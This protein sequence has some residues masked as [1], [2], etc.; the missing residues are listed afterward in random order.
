MTTISTNVRASLPKLP[1]I[2]AL[3]V[4]ML[5]CFVF[6]KAQAFYY[7]LNSK[8]PGCPV[9]KRMKFVQESLNVNES[10]GLWKVFL[11]LLEYAF[12]NYKYYSKRSK[13]VRQEIIHKMKIIE[14]IYWKIK[15]WV[16]RNSKFL[17]FKKQWKHK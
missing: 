15:F 8:A 13:L 9:P 16:G 6:G 3:D 11:A 2:K 12:V 17:K 4:Y 14:G 7:S 10:L 5:M 1:D